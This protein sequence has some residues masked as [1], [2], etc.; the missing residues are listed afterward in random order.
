MDSFNRMHFLLRFFQIMFPS[1]DSSKA[2]E[3]SSKQVDHSKACV[4]GKDGAA[5]SGN[6]RGYT[7]LQQ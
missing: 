5:T 3:R 6:L 7:T 1:K 4:A 2:T